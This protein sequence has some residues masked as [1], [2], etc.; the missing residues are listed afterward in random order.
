M[1]NL[2]AYENFIINESKS[3]LQAEDL[4]PEKIYQLGYRKHVW[5][6]K[7]LG[8]ELD[9]EKKPIMKFIDIVDGKPEQDNIYHAYMFNGVMSIGTSADKLIFYKEIN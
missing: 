9:E 1:K 4:E 8:W 6:A 5:V 7:F 3:K 2:P